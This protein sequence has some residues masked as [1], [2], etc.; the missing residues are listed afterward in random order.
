MFS[1]NGKQLS[2]LSG[3]SYRHVMRLTAE[4]ILPATRDASGFITYDQKA[5]DV[6]LAYVAKPR[7]SR[8]R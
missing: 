8:R 6:L 7:G 1:M 3:I 2:K 5:L 4:G